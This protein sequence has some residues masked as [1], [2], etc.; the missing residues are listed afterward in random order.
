MAG[1]SGGTALA[2]L[3]SSLVTASM[4]REA[5]SKTY[6]QLAQDYPLLCDQLAAMVMPNGANQS[7]IVDYSL[8]VADAY[9]KLLDSD[10][11]KN[12]TLYKIFRA[13]PAVIDSY[14]LLPPKQQASASSARA[15][16]TTS[17]GS[18]S[19]SDSSSGADPLPTSLAA[20]SSKIPYTLRV[21]TALTITILGLMA[22]LNTTDKLVAY[23]NY[24]NQFLQLL[25]PH[26]LNPRFRISAPNC[27]T[28]M[29]LMTEHMLP[30]FFNNLFVRAKIATKLLPATALHEVQPHI[31]KTKAAL[32]S[33]T[34][35]DLPAFL[36]CLGLDHGLVVGPRKLIF[37][38]AEQLQRN[39]FDY[40]LS[41]NEVSPAVKS[42][43]M[44]RLAMTSKAKILI[45]RIDNYY[46]LLDEII[47]SMQTVVC[48]KRVDPRSQKVETYFFLSSLPQSESSLYLIHHANKECEM[49]LKQH[50]SYL[51]TLDRN[52]DLNADINAANGSVGGYGVGQGLSQG[53]SLSRVLGAGIGLGADVAD[54]SDNG[55]DAASIM[56]DLPQSEVFDHFVMQILSF[57]RDLCAEIVGQ[58]NVKEWDEVLYQN[59]E[60]PIFSFTSL[61]YY[62]LSDVISEEQI[63]R[64]KRQ[65]MF[66]MLDRDPHHAFVLR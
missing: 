20:T 40:L 33:L 18:G 66:E 19:D 31:A 26:M 61:C 25:L 47:T 21:D 14:A 8:H 57:D 60:N 6:E 24:A 53:P 29:R 27:R 11:Y 49:A 58:N 42:E 52:A 56:K 12:P 13:L 41:L 43:L 45:D 7:E 34:V 46:D 50:D 35:E 65:R 4:S 22:G 1:I 15:G 28:V 48:I 44:S 9:I 64:L 30:A 63:I 32:E 54:Y 55:V 59:G 36:P 17:T 39:G 37:L 3:Q 23:S 2:P 38:V 10:L 51:M 16:A 62:F 5:L